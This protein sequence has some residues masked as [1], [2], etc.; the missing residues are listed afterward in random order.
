[1][2]SS[3]GSSRPS[4]CGVADPIP[5]AARY[6]RA[7]QGPLV[8]RPAE[9]FSRGTTSEVESARIAS[10]PDDFTRLEHSEAAGSIFDLGD[11]FGPD[12]PRFEILLRKNPTR[13]DVLHEWLHVLKFRKG[14]LAGQSDSIDN[15]INGWLEKRKKLVG[16]DE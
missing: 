8:H 10:D 12:V 2:A 9:I 14:Y 4:C 7:A 5:A 3:T 16:L 6:T 11:S 15:W 13:H 1:M